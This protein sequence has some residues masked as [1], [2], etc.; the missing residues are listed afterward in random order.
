[1][2]A[3]VSAGPMDEAALN[4]ALETILEVTFLMLLTRL[5]C[6]TSW[7]M[8]YSSKIVGS[9]IAL[10]K[11]SVWVDQIDLSSKFDKTLVGGSRINS[12]AGPSILK[13]LATGQI[14]IGKTRPKG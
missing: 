6:I 4:K 2:T 9:L 14:E 13:L 11:P 7:R 1:M 8:T 12:V 5:L 3:K 10:S